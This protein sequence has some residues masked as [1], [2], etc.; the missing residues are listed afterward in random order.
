MHTTDIALLVTDPAQIQHCLPPLP[1]D[2][3]ILPWHVSAQC[4][5]SLE[6]DFTNTAQIEQQTPQINSLV[7]EIDHE[8]PWVSATF[9]VHG[10]GEGVV[11]YP[12]SLWDSNVPKLVI[13]TNPVSNCS[14][15][16]SLAPLHLKPKENIMQWLS[17]K[18]RSIRLLK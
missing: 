17:Q 11:W 8:D 12:I 10:T 6:F 9:G 7:A 2:V 13:F 3:H 5:E 4:G 14:Q 1:Q 16:H 15:C 18:E